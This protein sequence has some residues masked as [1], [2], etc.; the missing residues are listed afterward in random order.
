MKALLSAPDCGFPKKNVLVFSVNHSVN[1]GTFFQ[2]I[3]ISA[4]GVAKGVVQKLLC[5]AQAV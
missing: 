5:P 1:S 2:D 4:Y 3:F